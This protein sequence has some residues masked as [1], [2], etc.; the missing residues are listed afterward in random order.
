M[1]DMQYFR[2]IG[3]EVVV[4]SVIALI[5]IVV[6]CYLWLSSHDSQSTRRNR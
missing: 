4:T 2:G 1:N 6:L 3:N 5:L